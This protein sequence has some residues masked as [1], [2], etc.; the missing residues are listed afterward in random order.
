VNFFTALRS[1]KGG[2]PAKLFHVST[3]R[4]S[5]PC[6]SVHLSITTLNCGWASESG[7]VSQL[8][9]AVGPPA[10]RAASNALRTYE[11]RPEQLA[12]P[13]HWI[14]TVVP[15]GLEYDPREI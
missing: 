13:T 4:L 10:L 5:W 12:A 15:A 8:A 2:A 1:A 6:A 14:A 3:R 7:A 9:V 11:V